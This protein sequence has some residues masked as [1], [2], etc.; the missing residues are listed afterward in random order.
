MVS[1]KTQ[2]GN[3]DSGRWRKPTR[4]T[5]HSACPV[6]KALVRGEFFSALA[7]L[8]NH[9]YRGALLLV[10]IAFGPGRLALD[11][12]IARIGR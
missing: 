8:Q 7:D 10:L 5:H 1:I 11:Y 6:L 9:F 3:L 12:W 4:G 2:Y